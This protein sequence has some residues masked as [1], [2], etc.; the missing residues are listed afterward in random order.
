MATLDSLPAALEHAY[1]AQKTLARATAVFEAPEFGDRAR[2]DLIYVQGRGDRLHA[3]LVIG[4]GDAS[5]PALWERFGA[6][7]AN[8]CWIVCERR[9]ASQ[10]DALA[11]Q[12]NLGLLI[13]EGAR[14]EVARKAPPR[15]GIFIKKYKE[16][17]K[18]WRAISPW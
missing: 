12:H 18:E 15:P 2:G 11:T 4:E 16:L 3:L 14:V 6:C 7:D 1:P 17:R 10:L 13:Q 9:E 8:W 5:D